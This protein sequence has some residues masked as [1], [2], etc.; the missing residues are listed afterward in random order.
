[1][2]I[3][4]NRIDAARQILD[5]YLEAN[6]HRKTP[7][8]YAILET[9]YSLNGHFSLEQLGRQM[10]QDCF[11]VS[12]ATLYNT[13]RLFLKLRLVA[14]HRLEE[15]TRYEACHSQ[16]HSHQI[17]TMCG[18]VTEVDLPLVAKAIEESRLRRFRK[19]GFTLYIY[20]VCS[21]CQAQ[22]TKKM[23]SK[24]KHKRNE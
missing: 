20:G 23:K 10:E 11:R 3:E 17:C 6:N 7:E 4:R 18:V 21:S 16:R 13:M 9:I 1:M 8:R 12:R 14:R 15:G 19:E 5:S 24:N 2:A 22:I